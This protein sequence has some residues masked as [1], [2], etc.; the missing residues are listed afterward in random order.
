MRGDRV[1]HHDGGGKAGAQGGGN[2]K[3]C[4]EVETK[5]Q[6]IVLGCSKL[7]KDKQMIRRSPIDDRALVFSS[8]TAT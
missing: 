3:A 5:A 6:K 7:S 2:E 8:M 1:E 4:R